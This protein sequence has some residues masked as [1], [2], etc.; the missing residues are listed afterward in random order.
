M[1]RSVHK[2]I[3][4]LHGSAELL[5]HYQVLKS[6]HLKTSTTLLDLAI[7]GWKHAK[8]LSSDHMKEF[9][10]VN[11]LWAKAAFDHASEENILVKHEMK[12]T[13]SH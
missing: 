4:A 9:H 1:Y 13:A 3:V 2:A 11:W 12:W 8:L 10:R 7:S 5:S 6:E